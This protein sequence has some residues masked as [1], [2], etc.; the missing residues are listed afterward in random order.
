MEQVFNFG[1]SV[2][3]QI[4]EKIIRNTAVELKKNHSGILRELKKM[5]KNLLTLNTIFKK[6]F[7][8]AYFRIFY[9]ISMQL[10]IT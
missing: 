3:Q 6:K 7:Y 2:Q 10:L 9:F 1:V 4:E 5:L 8:T